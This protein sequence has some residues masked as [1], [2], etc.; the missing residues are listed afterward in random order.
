M[1]TMCVI[2]CYAMVKFAWLVPERLRALSF[3][4]CIGILILSGKY[5]YANRQFSRAENIY[6][7]PQ[8]VV[9]I[10]DEIIVPDRE[11][12][13]CFPV[14]MIQYVRQYTPL[15]GLTYGRDNLLWGEAYDNFSTI[16][17]LLSED[18]LDTKAICEELKRTVTQYFIVSQEKKLT[19]SPSLYDYDY[20]TN[21]DGYDIYL[22]RTANLTLDLSGGL[23]Y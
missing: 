12:R 9:D 14:E 17:P 15:V 6:H 20:L 5:V 23:Y 11:V 10:C 7:I 16:A 4:I 2:V 1:I 21:I 3:C 8:T 18:E 19:E 13:A 22:D